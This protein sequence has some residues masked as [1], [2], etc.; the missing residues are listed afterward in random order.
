MDVRKGYVL[1]LVSLGGFP[2]T[3]PSVKNM[4]RHAALNIIHSVVKPARDD[5]APTPPL[6]AAGR[7]RSAQNC[8]VDSTSP[9]LCG[10]Q[11]RS[12]LEEN[13]SLKKWV[14]RCCM[15]VVGRDL[16]ALVDGKRFFE[17]WT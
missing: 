13:T 11:P 3:A 12:R 15:F 8:L 1:V 5:A 17:R 16:N 9:T 4:S 14:A 7:R 6:S 2:V 10:R